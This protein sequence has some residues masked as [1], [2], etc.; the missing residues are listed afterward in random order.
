VPQ[1]R[2]GCG[3]E[4]K[5]SLLYHCWE[6][7]PGHS[8]SSQVTALTELTRHRVDVIA[9]NIFPSFFLSLRPFVFLWSNFM[10]QTN[11]NFNLI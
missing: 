6:P 2:S 7:N 11:L 4:E 10:K 3:G 5:G 8:A 1:S 9:T